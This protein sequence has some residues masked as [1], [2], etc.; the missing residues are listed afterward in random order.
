MVASFYL[1]LLYQHY[2]YSAADRYV[3]VHRQLLELGA[4]AARV[5][6]L[7]G[8]GGGARALA[9]PQVPPAAGH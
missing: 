5:A 1:S 6:P 7:A 3:A 9:Q 2:D 4:D 8:A